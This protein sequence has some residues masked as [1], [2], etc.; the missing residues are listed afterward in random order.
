MSAPWR[1]IA[2][3][4]VAL[5]VAL[6][7]GGLSGLV[8]FGSWLSALAA[9]LGATAAIV[10]IA[11]AA[12]GRPFLPSV[13][14]L[15]CGAWLLMVAFVPGPEGGRTWIPTPSALEGARVVA[16]EAVRYAADTVAPAEV[17]P[18]LAA[19]ITAGALALF[20]LVDAVA[21][22]AGFAASAGFLLVVPWLPALTL[23]R[24]IP[25][26]ALLGA[27]AAW[28][29]VVALSR[30]LDAGP[31]RSRDRAGAPAAPAA[32]AAV[33]ATLLLASIAAPLA[34]GGP[35]WGAAPRIALPDAL[36]GASRLDLDLDLRE[37]L[38]GRSTSPVLSY[39][40]TGG[41]VDVLR[42]YSFDTFDGNRW[43][44]ESGGETVPATGVLWPE[45]FDGWIEGESSFL[46]ISTT[47][48]SES[49]LPI[50][51]APRSIT[52]AAGWVY[53]RSTDEVV[54]DSPSGTRGLQYSVRQS[55]DFH[56]EEALR[57]A[58]ELIA[59]GGDE[60]VPAR[61]RELP[62]GID[63]KGLRTVATALTASA[64]DRYETALAL[65]EYLR[66][67]GFVYDTQVSPSGDDA[68]TTFLETRRGYCVQFATAMT[69][70]ARTLDIPARLAVGFLGGS[71]NVPGE[72]VVRGR[73]AHAWPELYFPGHG[74]VRFEPTPSVQ[75]GARPPYAEPVAAPEPVVPDVRD[76][77]RPTTAP[78]PVLP[79]TAP[80][81]SP[82]PTPADEG[83]FPWLAVG[84]G[85]LV[86]AAVAVGWARR[87]SGAGPVR[88]AEDAWA[89]LRTRLG[90]RAGDDALTPAET[91]RAI[92]DDGP[93]LGAEAREALGLLRMAVER[94]RYAPQGANGSDA[95]L[96]AWVDTV[97]TAA[98]EAERAAGTRR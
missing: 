81:T 47:D 84:T 2:T 60:V 8:V 86:L 67:P 79:T 75:T 26:L 25:T 92:L 59:A 45:P 22:G 34:E 48:L 21:V 85:A 27:L 65:Q 13:V 52:A 55:T 11:R 78:E 62:D 77:A 17:S 64:T 61:Y 1:L 46:T 33:A 19:A 51:A 32:A 88:D 83:G 10:V 6:G 74:W 49:R 40:S 76:T 9:V 91:E 57:A 93:E 72:Y 37:S 5:A 58:E 12:T 35:G 39:T 53:D 87:R 68:V 29:G 56:S 3:P 42:A 50:P 73:D 63:V 30:R 90:A 16:A 95:P 44:R 41:R 7:L 97:S 82:T 20:L 24:R 31:W 66:G 14:G 43:D 23:E 80:T 94:Q 70:M 36:G 89:L 4:L 54:S 69:V 28:L 71:E 15:V 96:R 98:R 18:A 38:N